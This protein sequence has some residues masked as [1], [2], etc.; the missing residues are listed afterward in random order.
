MFFDPATVDL[1]IGDVP[2]VR[3][4]RIV[5]GDWEKAAHQVMRN[6]SFVVT[7]DLKMGNGHATIMTSDLSEEYVTINAD[8]RS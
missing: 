8:Y 5:D 3:D 4:G 1:F 7:L 2:I 6:R